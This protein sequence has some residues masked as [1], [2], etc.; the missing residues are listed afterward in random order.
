MRNTCLWSKWMRHLRC[1]ESGLIVCLFGKNYL[2]MIWAFCLKWPAFLHS[3]LQPINDSYHHHHSTWFKAI[4]YFIRCVPWF[5]FTTPDRLATASN[6]GRNCNYAKFQNHR[7]EGKILP[8]GS[9]DQS[10]IHIHA[11]Q[12]IF[13]ELQ[14]SSIKTAGHPSRSGISKM[15]LV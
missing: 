9:C 3:F 7:V 15:P 8:C 12:F 1:Q 5:L 10:L 13:S 4:I 2:L 6:H 14:R 11:G